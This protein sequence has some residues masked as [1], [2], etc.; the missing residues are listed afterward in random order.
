MDE[1]SLFCLI[2]VILLIFLFRGRIVRH[3]F[4]N[5]F[6]HLI[7]GC[8]I[9]IIQKEISGEYI[10]TYLNKLVYPFFNLIP[11]ALDFNTWLLSSKWS[12]LLQTYQR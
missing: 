9:I 11:T 1:I 4:F 3:F 10:Y 7:F 6:M 5:L 8:E 12:H 2:K